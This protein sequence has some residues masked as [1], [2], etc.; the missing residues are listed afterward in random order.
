M[1]GRLILKW[2]FPVLELKEGTAE[3]NLKRLKENDLGM[4]TF[5]TG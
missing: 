3:E 4:V 5:I 2:I 1:Y